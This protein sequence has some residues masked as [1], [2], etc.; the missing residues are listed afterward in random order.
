MPEQLRQLHRQRL[1]EQVLDALAQY[2]AAEGLSVGDRLPSERSL[3]EQL[4]TSRSSVKQALI[5]LEVQGLIETRHG[6]GSYLRSTKLTGEPLEKLIDRRDR[7][8]DILDAREALESK[9]ASL[10]AVRRTAL[11]L[12]EIQDSLHYMQSEI[13]T[14]GD[15]ENADAKFHKAVTSAAYSG[16]LEQFMGQMSGQI[17]ESRKESLRQPGRPIQSLGQHWQV[18]RAIEAGDS[19]GAAEAMRQH[20][21]TV[22]NTLLL[23][24]QP[25]L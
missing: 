13:D 14:D 1:Y 8:P 16:V 11:D 5:A 25:D 23:N 17:A 10:A 21:A 12:Q 19:N 22:R 6:G 20:I 15:I 3:S 4:G 9:L 2:V 24:W 18:T 7:L